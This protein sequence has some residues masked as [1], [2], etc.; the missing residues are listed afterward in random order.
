MWLERKASTLIVQYSGERDAFFGAVKKALCR[1]KQGLQGLSSTFEAIL[2][3]SE[4]A[5]S[6]EALDRRP[7]LCHA[8]GI[9]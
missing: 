6:W 1:A 8:E 3:Q 7:N 2:V 4:R 5:I 9:E